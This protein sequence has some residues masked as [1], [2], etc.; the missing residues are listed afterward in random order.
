MP[1]HF[2]IAL[3]LLAALLVPLQAANAEQDSVTFKFPV[4]PELERH[5]EMLAFPA[6]LALALENNGFKPSYT[7]RLLVLDRE[8]FELGQASVRYLGRNGTSFR[9]ESSLKLSAGGVESVVN[10]PVEV[11]VAAISSG[12]LTI[13]VLSPLSKLLPQ[14]LRDRIEFKMRFFADAAAQRRMLQYLDETRKRVQGSSPERMV[15][16]ILMEAYNRGAPAASARRDVGDAEPMVDQLWF[17]ATLFI[18]LIAVP[19]AFFVRA[20]LRSRNSR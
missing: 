7:H 17:I 14:E 13:R 20:W 4:L 16:A 5:V 19:L 9:Y 1:R 6:Y 8:G 15:E 12:T 2:V 18:W 11:D 10:V 3:V